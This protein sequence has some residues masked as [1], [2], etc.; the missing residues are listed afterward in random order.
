LVGNTSDPRILWLYAAEM[1]ASTSREYSKAQLVRL[2]P[3]IGDT[4]RTGD[5]IRR[6]NLL[7]ATIEGNREAH[8]WLRGEQSV[9]VPEENASA[10]YG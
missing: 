4:S 3:G 10:T 6:L 7:K 8:A 9:F 5:I 2:N 1:R